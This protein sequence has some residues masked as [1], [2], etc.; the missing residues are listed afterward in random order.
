[1]PSFVF[2]VRLKSTTKKQDNDDEVTNPSLPAISLPEAI[3]RKIGEI[4]STPQVASGLEE[5]TESKA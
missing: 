4:C 2:F 1:M 5:G 3:E